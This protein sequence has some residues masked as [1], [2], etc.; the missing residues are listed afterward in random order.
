[1]AP[2]GGRSHLTRSRFLEVRTAVRPY[3]VPPWNCT[4]RHGLIPCDLAY[5]CWDLVSLGSRSACGNDEHFLVE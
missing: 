4:S 2:N 3:R 5:A 1:M